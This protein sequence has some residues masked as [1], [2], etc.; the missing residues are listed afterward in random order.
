MTH[1]TFETRL[2]AAAKNCSAV[3]LLHASSG[4]VKPVLYKCGSCHPGDGMLLQC[5]LPTVFGK[6]NPYESPRSK[7]KTTD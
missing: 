2:A 1:R 6:P 4:I 3:L 5:L 7:L